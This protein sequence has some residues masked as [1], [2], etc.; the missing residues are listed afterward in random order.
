[1]NEFITSWTSMFTETVS[2]DT[3]ILLPYDMINLLY[4]RHWTDKQKYIPYISVTYKV[5]KSCRSKM[6]TWAHDVYD[7]H[8]ASSLYKTCWW[9]SFIYIYIYIYIYILYVLYILY[10]IIYIYIYTYKENGE[11][12]EPIPLSPPPQPPGKIPPPNFYSLIAS[13]PKVNFPTY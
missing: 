11:G 12:G 1:M 10:N 6:A 13:A 3:E 4:Y 2:K 7:V 8:E 9:S 5:L